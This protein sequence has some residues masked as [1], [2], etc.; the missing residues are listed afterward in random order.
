MLCTEVMHITMNWLYVWNKPLHHALHLIHYCSLTI[1]QNIFFVR[2]CQ[3]LT[4]VAFHLPTSELHLYHSGLRDAIQF[5]II[6]LFNVRKRNTSL[7][8][9]YLLCNTTFNHVQNVY[10]TIAESAYY[11]REILCLWTV[12]QKKT[13]CQ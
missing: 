9:S 6:Q 3:G 4:V 2:K 12:K 8:K 11:K 7:I 1:I 13:N 10:E 5:S